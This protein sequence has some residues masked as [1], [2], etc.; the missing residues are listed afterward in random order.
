KNIKACE[1]HLKDLKNKDLKYTFDVRKA[2]RV[3]KFL[4]LLPDPKTGKILKLAEFQK[5]IAGSLYGWVDDIGNRRF[6]KSYRSMR[7]K[8]GETILLSGLSLYEMMMGEQPINERLVVLTANSREQ[9]TI[10]YDM[11]TAQLNAIRGKSA[12]IK[13]VTKITESKKEIINT[14]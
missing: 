8:N 5:F 10:A 3:I 13:D 6:T 7:R 1:R 9:A 14:R 11:V 2:N 12:A 4:E